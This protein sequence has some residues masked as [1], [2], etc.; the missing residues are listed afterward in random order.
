MIF[1][2][3]DAYELTLK[4]DVLK[5]D[6]VLLYPIFDIIKQCCRQGDF[7]CFVS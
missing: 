5:M 7:D 1:T 2:S 3:H 4:E 6:V